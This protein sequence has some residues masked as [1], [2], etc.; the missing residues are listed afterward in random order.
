MASWDA[1]SWSRFAIAAL[2]LGL[3]ACGDSASTPTPL[4]SPTVAPTPAPTPTPGVLVAQGS[5]PLTA[6]QVVKWDF[7]TP[8]RGTLEVTVDYTS[9]G[10]VVALWVTDHVCSYRQFE[11]D[12]CDYL[13]RSVEGGKPRKVTASNVAEGE[14]S[15]FVSNEGPGDEVISWKVVLLP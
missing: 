6:R 9:A 4:P 11:R 3:G 14:Y 8:A 2:A 7:K 12:D 10:N 1:L 13:A 15:L 5:E